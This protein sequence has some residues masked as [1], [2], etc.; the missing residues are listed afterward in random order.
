MARRVSFP[1]SSLPAYI[2]LSMKLIVCLSGYV[3]SSFAFKVETDVGIHWCFAP[4]WLL[5]TR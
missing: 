1:P 2:E 3:L 5:G 4:L